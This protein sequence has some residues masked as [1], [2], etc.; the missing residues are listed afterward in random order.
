MQVAPA[1]VAL[2]HLQVALQHLQMAL[3]HLQVAL[4]HL[5]VA[6]QHPPV[7]GVKNIGALLARK[8]E[9]PA[10]CLSSP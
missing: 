5:Q 1:T 4:Q 7:T 8:H 9:A 10:T 3:Q 2:Q 6:L